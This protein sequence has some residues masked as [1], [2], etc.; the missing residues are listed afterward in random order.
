MSYS[1]HYRETVSK[2]VSETVSVSYPASQSGGTKS[3][4]V[5]M[6]VEIPVDINIVVDTVPF[7]KSVEDCGFNVNLLTTAVVE[8]ES[9]TILSKQKNSN[10][11]AEA[12]I[13]GFFSY[14]KS[15]IS[16]Q[17][18]EIMQ[19]TDSLFMHIK[20]LSKVC[21]SKKDQMESDYNR[22]T[23]RYVKAFSDL[24]NELANRIHQLD[25]PAFVFKKEI[26]IQ[27]LR[28][29]NNDLISTVSAFGK[30]S[31]DLQAKTAASLAKQRALTTLNKVKFFLMQQNKLALTLRN[32][33]LNK[34]VS[35]P[36]YSPVC[37]LEF[38]QN[39]K[40]SERRIYISDYLK[41]NDNKK[42]ESKLLEAF[43][44]H[45]I[46]WVKIPESDLQRIN[47]HFNKELNEKYFTL[48]AHS[49][50]VREMIRTISNSNNIFSIN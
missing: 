41:G 50:R 7:D 33:M 49:T 34:S 38:T 11:I 30:E 40:V 20:E 23:S 14:V 4:T 46:D 43:S 22:I 36:I 15:E 26:E 24:N 9:A 42:Y 8:T 3:A 5:S 48:D 12:I 17:I 31:G 1:R 44:A 2:T 6:Y 10:K 13:G 35:G 32:C 28:A 21:I 29:Y 45:E 18:S 27:Q 47:L 16:Q 39:N 19:N 37:L 25:K